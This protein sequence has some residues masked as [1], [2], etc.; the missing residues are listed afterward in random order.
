MKL[1]RDVYLSN[2]ICLASDSGNVTPQV[3]NGPQKYLLRRKESAG[4]P[5]KENAA[6]NKLWIYLQSTSTM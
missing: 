6:G 5:I 4:S 2:E 3:I 1:R